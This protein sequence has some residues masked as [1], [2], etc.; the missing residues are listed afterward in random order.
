MESEQSEQKKQFYLTSLIDLLIEHSSDHCLET[1][2]SIS[3]FS[4]YLSP[5]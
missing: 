1:K 3:L 5:Y 4:Q 2:Q